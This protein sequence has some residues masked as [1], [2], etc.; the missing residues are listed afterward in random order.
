MWSSVERSA[1]RE[2]LLDLSQFVNPTHRIA[3]VCVFSPEDASRLSV[4]LADNQ[5]CLPLRRL[6]E[7]LGCDEGQ[8]FRWNLDHKLVQNIILHEY[9]PDLI[10][11]SIGLA[12]A[13]LDSGAKSLRCCLETL[14]PRGY[15][16]KSVR[17]AGSKLEE[18]R[19]SSDGLCGDLSRERILEAFCGTPLSET[20]LAQEMFLAVR[21]YRVH[22]IGRKV[23]P[24]LTFLKHYVRGAPLTLSEQ[25]EGITPSVAGR[26]EVEWAVSRALDRFPDGLCSNLICGWDVGMNAS[27]RFQVFEINFSGNHPVFRPGFQCSNYFQFRHG[28]ALN[29]ARLLKF[30]AD[31]YSISF[32][33]QFAGGSD[34]V[35]QSM[36]AQLY[37]IRCWKQLLE[38]AD[39]VLT[40]WADTYRESIIDNSSL[41]ALIRKQTAGPDDNKY[42]SYLDCLKTMTDCLR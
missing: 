8:P 5:F 23:I 33:F 1:L 19:Q 42:A 37:R 12:R 15:V 17:G 25:F 28:S 10:P 35:E 22:S 18:V 36:V 40:M 6:L 20:W 39:E 21:E 11:D 29:I 13:L 32:K 16:I 34:P 38:V 3:S 4:N 41:R 2:T 30:A 7:H 9:I 14:Y 24:G 31:E 27:N 26:E